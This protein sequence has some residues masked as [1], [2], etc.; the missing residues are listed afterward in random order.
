MR[1]KLNLVSFASAI[2]LLIFIL[3]WILYGEISFLQTTNLFFYPAGLFLILGV[4]GLVIRS[5]SFDFFHYSVNKATRLFRK[6]SSIEDEERP[7]SHLSNQFGKGYTVLL[8]IGL[9]LMSISLLSLMGFYL[10]ER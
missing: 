5:G 7:I 10:F 6:S 8:K 2:I 4:F 9:I 3:E 1:I